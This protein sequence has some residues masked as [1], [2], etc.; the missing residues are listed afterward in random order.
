LLVSTGFRLIATNTGAN[1]CGSAFS[2]EVEVTV[3]APSTLQLSA[4]VMLEGA[5]TGSTMKAGTSIHIPTAQPYN[6][7]PWNYNGGE[8]ATIGSDVVDWVL[9]ELRQAVD[10]A[11]ATSSTVLSKRAALLKTDGSIVDVSGTGPVT[12]NIGCVN[13]GN[14]LYVVVRHRNHLAIMSANGATLTSGVYNYDFTTNV[15]QAYG[16]T[17]GFKQVGTVSAMVAGDIDH[18]GSVAVSDYNAWAAG[19]GLTNA[20]YGFDL[21]MDGSVAVS[22]YNKWAA[23]FGL[24]INNGLK[25]ASIKPTYVSCVPK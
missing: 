11:S 22:D 12:F 14:N 4:K 23:N 15:T 13:T 25:S 6:T 9:V 24:N 8:T 7:A 3:L 18:D 16:G 19:F 5:V 17:N 20:Y 21:D 2:N 1:N 10:G